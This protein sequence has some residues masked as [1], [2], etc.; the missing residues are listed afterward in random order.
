[1]QNP[2]KSHIAKK[3]RPAPVDTGRFKSHRH[4][5]AAARS[6]SI[7]I[8]MYRKADIIFSVNSNVQN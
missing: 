5:L 8:P 1:M 7:P 4:R 3:E 6:K 2:D